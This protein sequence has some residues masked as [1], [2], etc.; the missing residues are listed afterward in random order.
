[1]DDGG[2]MNCETMLT[3][4]KDGYQVEIPESVIKQLG[5]ICG[6][7]FDV[8]VDNG[9]VKLIPVVVYPKAKVEELEALAHEARKLSLSGDALVY[10]DVE[11]MIS[12][13]H[14]AI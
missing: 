11:N 6:D 13:L 2:E 1:M 9:V 3:G 12:D 14:R 7:M 4:L 10:D 5:L 8:V